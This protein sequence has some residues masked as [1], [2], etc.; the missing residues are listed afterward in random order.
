MLPLLLRDI[1]ISCRLRPPVLLR[2]SLRIR[3]H[4]W[5]LLSLLLMLLPLMLLLG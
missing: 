2:C 1:V 5:L 4:L 3:L